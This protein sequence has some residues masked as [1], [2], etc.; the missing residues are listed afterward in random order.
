[1]AK[2]DYLIVGAGLFGAVFAREAVDSGKRCLIID[3]RAHVGG[4]VYTEKVEG[5]T[6]HR[7]GPHIFH[8][9]DREVWDY[10]CRFAEFNRFVNAPLAKYGDEVYN[11][12]FNMNTFYRLWGV[13]DPEE[14]ERIITSQRL[15]TAEPRNLEEQALSLV[16]KT[17]YEKLVRGYTEKQWGK[18]CKD[19]PAFIIRRLPLRF[20]WDN[21]YFSDKFQGI[22]ENGYTPIIDKLIE[23]CEVQLNTDFFKEQ[24]ALKN[25]ASKIV[26]TG[27]LDEFYDFIH[28]SLE[29]RGLRF[30]TEVLDRPN[31]QGNA[32]VNYV[33]RDVPWTRIV[34]HKHFVSSEGLK[35]VITREYPES[36]K[37]GKEPFYPVNSEENNRIASLYRSMANKEKNVIFGGRL[38]DYAY[39]DM[40]QIVRKA[41]NVAKQECKT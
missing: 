36:F 15:L 9:D 40:W 28:G 24:D 21:S 14:A 31:F 35:T 17:I 38:G 25:I 8:T 32:V 18:E 30:E 33:D 19:L 7:Y 12:P 29:Y 2:Y 39:Y 41:L 11:L 10:M 27:M 20:T 13:S 37:N 1:M 22:P 5:I 4:N 3:K 34:E 6:V 26:Y 16:G 23:G